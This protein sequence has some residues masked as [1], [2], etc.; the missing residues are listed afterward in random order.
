MKASDTLD[1]SR[2]LQPRFGA[3]TQLGASRVLPPQRDVPTLGAWRV[4]Q[5][6]FGPCPPPLDASRIASQLIDPCVK[7]AA[8]VAQRSAWRRPRWE[9][10]LQG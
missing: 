10:G 8:V 4:L 1:A 9:R 7:V 3:G 6:Q 2:V 5:R